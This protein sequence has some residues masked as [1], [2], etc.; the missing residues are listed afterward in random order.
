MTSGGQGKRQEWVSS[1]GDT[2]H[3]TLGTTVLEAARGFFVETV[4]GPG[5]FG[6]FLHDHLRFYIL[7]C[8]GI[9]CDVGPL[10]HHEIIAQVNTQ[11]NGE[12]L[13]VVI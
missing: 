3:R 8:S 6:H 12:I 9:Y 1:G 13:R 4:V 2:Y 10:E 11:A 7:V 5:G